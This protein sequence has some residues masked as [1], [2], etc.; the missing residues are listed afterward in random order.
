MA[1]Y[2]TTQLRLAISD[3]PESVYN[4]IKIANTDV[5]RGM[6]TTGR[7]P[8]VP[9]VEKFDDTGKV[10][11]GQEFP[12]QQRS[13]FLV[14]P[15]IEITEELNIDIVGLLARRAMGGAVTM[16]AVIESGGG[17]PSTVARPHSWGL[18]MDI[19]GQRQLPSSS[20]AWSVGGADYIWG[21]VVGESF[22]IDQAGVG[23]PTVTV[24]MLGSGLHKKI[25]TI[26]TPPTFPLPTEQ[27]YMLGPDT[28]VEFTDT[29]L[30]SLTNARKL[31]NFTMTLTNNHLTDDRRPGDPPVDPTNPNAGWYTDRMFYGDRTIASEMTIVIDDDMRELANARDDVAITDFTFRARGKFLTNADGSFT[32]TANRATFE[33]KFPKC[34]FRNIRAGDDAGRAVITVSIVPVSVGGASPMQVKV[35]TNADT[36]GTFV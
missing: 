34:Y 14:Y 22:R 30:R 6:L 23:N 19:S 26:A 27:R 13:G 18:K 4:A 1:E 11:A 8:I 12:T 25:S 35:I 31:L 3:T 29:A 16:G 2:R 32:S 28:Q 24:G 5:Y 20:V 15:A 10:G 9:D 36:A 21:G 7:N 33:V 17:V